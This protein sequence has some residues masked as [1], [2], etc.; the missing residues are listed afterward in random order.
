ASASIRAR[1]R[2]SPLSSTPTA[3]I[4]R[5]GNTHGIRFRINPPV[6]ASSSA[7]A[8]PVLIGLKVCALAS[9][10]AGPGSLEVPAASEA[11]IAPRD[12]PPSTVF[13]PTVAAIGPPPDVGRVNVSVFG[14]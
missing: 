3:L 11:V 5:M 6:K 7:K 12:A 1:W 8:S 9:G 13:P 10:A 2:D 4:A 14:G